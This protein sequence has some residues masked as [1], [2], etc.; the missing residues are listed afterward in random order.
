MPAAVANPYIEQGTPWA[1]GVETDIDYLGLLGR[2]WLRHCI[3]GTTV[4][5]LTVTVPTVGGQRID[6]SLTAAQTMAIPCCGRTFSETESYNLLVELYDPNDAAVIYRL[7]NG[8]A[9]VSPRGNP[10]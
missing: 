6:V 8:V 4:A 5:T 10:P 2:G 9:R 3:D 7:I 1:M